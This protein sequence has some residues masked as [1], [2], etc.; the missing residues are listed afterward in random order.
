MNIAPLDIPNAKQKKKKKKT[1]YAPLFTHPLYPIVPDTPS[2]G[3]LPDGKCKIV[4]HH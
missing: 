4:I 3:F 2:H 1:G